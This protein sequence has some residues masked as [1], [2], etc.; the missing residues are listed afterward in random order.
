MSRIYRAIRCRSSPAP[1]SLGG[2]VVAGLAMLVWLKAEP[3][4]V[5][6]MAAEAPGHGERALVTADEG[7]RPLP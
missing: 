2:Y 5:V 1:A 4:P 7:V 3:G 6:R